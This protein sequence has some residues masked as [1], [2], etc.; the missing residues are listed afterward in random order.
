ML[1]SKKP[2]VIFNHQPQPTKPSME[3]SPFPKIY[4]Y[5]HLIQY[6]ILTNNDLSGQM[7][8]HFGKK[9]QKLNE[10]NALFEEKGK[11]SSSKG[12]KD[13]VFQ[14]D[15]SN[16]SSFESNKILTLPPSPK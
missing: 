4:I 10:L 3:S 5:S 2:S 16:K 9:F 6:Q 7:L 12:G 14:V 1:N 13:M 15:E 8:I 11:P